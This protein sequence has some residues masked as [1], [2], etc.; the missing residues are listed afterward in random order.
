[1]S[2]ALAPEQVPSNWQNLVNGATS[3]TGRDLVIRAEIVAGQ[4][5]PDSDQGRR[6]EIQVQRLAEGLG[7]GDQTSPE[8]ELERLIALWCLHPEMNEQSAEHA[9]RLVQALESRLQH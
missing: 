7:G 1:M 5:T 3:L 9:G 8:Q 6:M 4:E 2:G